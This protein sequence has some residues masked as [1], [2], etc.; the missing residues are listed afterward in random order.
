MKATDDK[1][2]VIASGSATGTVKGR[3]Q[4]DDTV[5]L[6]RSPSPERDRISPVGIP[7][8]ATTSILASHTDSRPL[9]GRR[10][11]LRRDSPAIYKSPP[12]ETDHEG[13]TSSDEEVSPTKCQERERDRPRPQSARVRYN[14]QDGQTVNTKSAA[15]IIRDGDVDL[16]RRK[17]AWSHLTKSTNSHILSSNINPSGP[18]VASNSPMAPLTP[19]MASLNAYVITASDS[20]SSQ[21]TSNSLRT[22][23]ITSS[24][25]ALLERT[26]NILRKKAAQ[27]PPLRGEDVTLEDLTGQQD[28]HGPARPETGRMF[29]HRKITVSE[30]EQLQRLL[31]GDSSRTFGDEWL[32]QGLEFSREDSHVA[33]GLRQSKGG[34]CGVLAVTQAYIFKHLLWP[35]GKSEVGDMSSRLQ[36]TESSRRGALLRAI[37]EIL[38]QAGGSD[39]LNS[40]KT[41]SGGPYKYVLGKVAGNSQRTAFTSLTIYNLP[42]SEQLMG[43]LTQHQEEI[44]RDGVVQ[45]LISVL[46]CRGVDNIRKDMDSPDHALI[47]RHNHTTQEVVNLML[48]GRAVSNL[49]DDR[50]DVEGTILKGVQQRSTCGLL[51]LVEAYGIIEVGSYLKCPIFPIWVLISENHYF[52]LFATSV[53][54]LDCRV[55]FELLVYDGLANS[56][57]ATVIKVDPSRT[58]EDAADE[59]SKNP[60]E[61]CIRTKWKGALVDIIED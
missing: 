24:A 41:Q 60:V 5:H 14:A 57:N 42:T 7:A 46:L 40:V 37:H 15:V 4:L 29:A 31:F 32:R 1:P 18:A 16:E 47:G 25:S 49:F 27:R 45:L 50:L 61:L 20:P 11:A 39:G 54:V 56:E 36:V 26:D 48:T 28:D 38:V 44:L 51:S 43:F 23:Q 59:S 17:S 52:V 12:K 13:L 3:L 30:N 35:E 34:P 21:E 6:L 2:F 58:R 55:P 22:S 9:L 8:K 19:A 10:S 33:Y 53:A